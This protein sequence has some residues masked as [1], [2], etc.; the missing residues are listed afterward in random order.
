MKQYDWIET[1]IFCLQQ[2]K[3][4]H[5]DLGRVASMLAAAA[6]SNDGQ[7]RDGEFAWFGPVLSGVVTDSGYA[8]RMNMW[9]AK[10][11]IQGGKS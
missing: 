9:P 8:D 7:P 2:M 3:P 1:L 10:Q 4:D 5:P 11:V 6:E